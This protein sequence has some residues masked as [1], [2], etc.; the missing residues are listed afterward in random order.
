MAE[1]WGTFAEMSPFLLFGFAI[2]GVLSVLVSR[3][4]VRRHL[5]GRGLWPV[6]KASLLGIPLPLCSC[7]VIPVSMSLREHGASKGSTVAFLL[8]TPQTGVDSVFV[9]LSLLGPVFALFRPL[10]ALV[11]GLVGGIVTNAVERAPDE[12]APSPRVTEPTCC[13]SV[14]QNKLRQALTYGFV[15]LPRDIGRTLLIGLAIAALVG[16]VTPPDFF[17]QTL[18]TGLV[19]M[20][21]MMVLGIPMYVCATASVPLAAML[22]LKGVTP[23]AALVFLMTG[24]ATNAASLT[25]IWKRLGRRVALAYLVTVILCAFGSGLLLDGLLGTQALQVVAGSGAM[26]NPMVKHLSSVLLIGVI[27]AALLGKRAGDQATT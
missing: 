24:P 11:T 1:F 26:L 12:D 7:S 18:G 23:G 16:T 9:T 10:C 15:T 21:V 14:S 27:G 8:S 20:A 25:L 17:A 4:F 22:I 19:A 5:G 3:D 13:C 6:F 2:A